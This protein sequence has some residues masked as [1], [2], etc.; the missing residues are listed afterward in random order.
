VLRPSAFPVA[1]FGNG[2]VGRALVQVLGALPA[3]VTWIDTREH[4]F[5]VAV[6]GNV[7]IVPTDDPAGEVAS[8]PHG[9][10][11]VVMT[12]SHALDFAIVEAALA[13]EDWRYVG[14]I[15]SAAKR[16]QFEHR[17]LRLRRPR[18]DMARITCPIGATLASKEPGVI[19]V[20]VAAELLQVRERGQAARPQERGAIAATAE[21]GARMRASRPRTDFD[22]DPH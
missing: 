22:P 14:L 10:Y 18:E 5:P 3:E 12:H 20:G 2:H 8:L 19:A 9:A 1:V 17:L 7:A 16:T 21:I 6:P 11:L 4:D 13:R 15:G